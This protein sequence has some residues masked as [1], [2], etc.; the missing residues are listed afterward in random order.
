MPSTSKMPSKNTREVLMEGIFEATEVSKPPTFIVLNEKLPD[1]PTEEEKEQLLQIAEH[2]SGVT[3]NG[4]PSTTEAA[5]RLSS[6]KKAYTACKEPY[7]KRNE[8]AA[9]N[10]VEHWLKYCYSTDDKIS[11][12]VSVQ[13]KPESVV[14]H[15]FQVSRDEIKTIPRDGAGTMLV[16]ASKSGYPKVVEKLLKDKD[17][18]K[19]ELDAR[20]QELKDGEAQELKD[21][22]AAMGSSWGSCVPG[23]I[24]SK[25]PAP[26]GLTLARQVAY[27][28]EQG[29]DE[30]AEER[31]GVN[32]SQERCKSCYDMITLYT[33]IGEEI[34]DVPTLAC[35][36]DALQ[37]LG[38]VSMD[39]IQDHWDDVRDGLRNQGK[40][41]RAFVTRLSEARYNYGSWHNK[42]T[43]GMLLHDFFRHE[44]IHEPY[45]TSPAGR[46]LVGATV[47]SFLVLVPSGVL[48][49]YYDLAHYE[50]QLWSQCFAWLF[51]F[52][53]AQ[54]LYA[55]STAPFTGWNMIK[56][57]S[58][59]KDLGVI[60]RGSMNQQGL[61]STLFFST[62][63][64]R[65]Q[66]N[67]SSFDLT[68]NAG[69]LSSFDTI[70][71]A[72]RNAADYTLAEH[73]LAQWYAVSHMH[74]MLNA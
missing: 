21:R 51:I 29:E 69:N 60:L 17:V 38:W 37:K 70:A 25:G 30:S 61:V 65:L 15:R 59:D 1:P 49:V 64:S 72:D 57:S 33:Y 6:V 22:K 2:G 14:M 10:A 7:S 67:L 56:E 20:A 34:A 12:Y 62:I 71:T 13:I 40:V 52:A 28:S 5:S 27:F 19:F 18:V 32:G 39:D 68:N 42:L 41:E 53:V 31:E 55:V 63:M 54:L 66:I 11:D 26:S 58:R 3:M 36:I 44:L 24:F 23:S 4:G 8:T 35:V 9:V 74:V 43:S 47:L 73:A 46:A 48:V 45:L 50:E 16:V